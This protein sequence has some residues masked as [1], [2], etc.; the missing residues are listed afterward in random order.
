MNKEEFKRAL[1]PL[2]DGLFGKQGTKR[3]ERPHFPLRP[4]EVMLQDLAAIDT[5]EWYRYVFSR[6]P[7]NGKFTD[8]QRRHWME[9][10]LE[11][12]RKYAGI[13]CDKYQT[14]DP[15]ELAKAMGMKVSYP[16]FPEKADRVLF[17]EYREPDMINIFMDAVSKAKKYLDRP[18][19]R[20]ILTDQL[21][22][23][24]LLL[25][26]ELFHHVEEMYRKEIFTK[27]ETIRLWSVGPVHNDSQIIALSEIAAM[28]FA[29]EIIQLPYAPYVL[30]MFL[31]YGY[32]PEEASGLYE[33]MMTMAGF[34]P[35][36]PIQ[37]ED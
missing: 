12:G 15:K 27:T 21:H 37:A 2:T 22:V 25:S 10:S 35:C 1:K 9:Q 26:H 24:N 13:I 30:D 31:V 14:K 8:E 20:E 11:C 16:T 28:A 33:E 7:L 23:A 6:E 36:E 18:G 17:A 34:T 5:V 19:I 29:Q 32:S 4:L 3:Y